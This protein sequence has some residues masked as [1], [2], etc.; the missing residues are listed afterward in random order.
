MMMKAAVALLLL[1]LTAA[2]GG[3]T[4]HLLPKLGGGAEPAC[5]P[6]RLDS[7]ASLDFEGFIAAPWYSQK[8]VTVSFQPDPLFCVLARYVP[9]STRFG[10]AIR[11]VN[12]ANRGAVNGPPVCTSC[13]VGNVLNLSAIIAPGPVTPTSGSKLIVAPTA[14]INNVPPPAISNFTG[15]ANYRVVAVGRSSDAKLVYRWA[16]II[17]GAKA[18]SL[19]ASKG[20]CSP[21]P[22][23]DEGFW[24]FHREPQAPLFDVLEMI[25]TA[26]KLGISPERLVKVTQAGCKYEGAFF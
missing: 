24:L 25:A 7:V 18:P 22:A 6:P 20:L 3:A 14:V 11:V 16:I 8:Q 9:A 26:V 1:C 17:S 12:Y 4:A 13:P 15:G 21:D 2:V 5:P 10:P 19:P 23:K